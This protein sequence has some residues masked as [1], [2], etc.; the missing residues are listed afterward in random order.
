MKKKV[1]SASERDKEWRKEDRLKYNAYQREYMRK[2]RHGV[3]K[4]PKNDLT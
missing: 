4:S 1:K 2:V 3:D